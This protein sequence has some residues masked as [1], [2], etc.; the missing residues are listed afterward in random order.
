M[1]RNFKVFPCGWHQEKEVTEEFFFLFYSGLAWGMQVRWRTAT[2]TGRRR[3]SRRP[4]ARR[5]RR[6]VAFRRRRLL[7]RRRWRRRRRRLGF[8]ERISKTSVHWLIKSQRG[9]CCLLI[10]WNAIRLTLNDIE[11]DF[12]KKKSRTTSTRK[13]NTSARVESGTGCFDSG[14][15]S[16]R[17]SV[18]TVSTS[19]TT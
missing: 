5:R 13:P 12:E 6:R 3:T 16:R 14:I 10:R 1:S 11:S 9:S 17:R 8:L 19:L 2:P 15:T 4:A 18:S 7:R